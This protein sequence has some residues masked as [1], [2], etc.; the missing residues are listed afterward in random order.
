[1]DVVV[2]GLVTHDMTNS[3]TMCAPT[4]GLEFAWMAGPVASVTS[5]SLSIYRF[6]H[7]TNWFLHCFT[8]ICVSAKVTYMTCVRFDINIC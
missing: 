4:T 2:R 3:D 6:S 1:M 5:V 8:Y 7:F